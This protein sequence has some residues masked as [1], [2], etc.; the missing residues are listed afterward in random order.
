MLDAGAEGFG[1]SFF[2][3]ETGRETLS[4]AGS[5]AA[6]RYFPISEYTGEEALAV[7]FDGT[8]DTWN[9]DQIDS[10]TDEHD[11]TVAQE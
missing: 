6:I 5:G 3:G 11:A 4:G 8:R 9:F 1:S 2:G 7:A 10:R